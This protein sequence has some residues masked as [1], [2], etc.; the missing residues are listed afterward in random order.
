MGYRG[1]AVEYSNLGQSELALQYMQKAFELKDRASEREKLAID[2]DYYQYSGQID[3]A[4]DAY[5]F[6][7]APIRGT[8]GQPQI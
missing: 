2:S 7:N 3:K 6:T 1:L 5:S 4:I 8:T